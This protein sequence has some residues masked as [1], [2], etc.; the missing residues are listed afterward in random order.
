MSSTIDLNGRLGN[1][2]YY[3]S[4]NNNI[5][6]GAIKFLKGYKRQSARLNVDQLIGGSLSTQISTYFSRSNTYPDGNWFNLTRQHPNTDL[7]ATDSK[8]RLYTTEG[9]LGRVQQFSPDG[10]PLRTWGS[11]GS[12]PGGFGASASLESPAFSRASPRL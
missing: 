3:G 7:L 8:G 4:F 10:V 1:T 11:K 6:Q 5:N 9:V 2:G 12:E